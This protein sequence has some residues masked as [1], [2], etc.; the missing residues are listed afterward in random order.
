MRKTL[1][2]ILALI[3]ALSCMG[4]AV[5]EP[6]DAE[7]V[8]EVVAEIEEV[9]I[10]ASNE[11]TDHN[12]TDP[13]KDTGEGDGSELPTAKPT[14]EP[15]PT[16]APTGK[17]GLDGKDNDHSHQPA[18]DAVIVDQKK[19]T[20]TEEGLRKVSKCK[21]CGFAYEVVIPKLSATGEHTFSAA[22]IEKQAS[23]CSVQGY[24]IY[25]KCDKCGETN[26]KVMLP[27]A[28]H[29]WEKKTDDPEAKE[30]T[31]TT[32]EVEVLVCK[33]CQTR[34]V[35]TLKDTKL[36]HDYKDPDDATQPY[37]PKNPKQERTNAADNIVPAKDATCTTEGR[38]KDM[39]ACW[40]CGALKPGQEQDGPAITLPLDHVDCIV[41]LRDGSDSE[42]RYFV[43]VKEAD[44]DKYCVEP[45]T[46][47]M[48]N[49]VGKYTLKQS[50]YKVVD[51]FWVSKA[52]GERLIVGYSSD[53]KADGAEHVVPA[54]KGY[55]REYYTA[56][57]PTCTTEGKITIKC[58][59]CGKVVERTIPA[60]GHKNKIDDNSDDPLYE[61]AKSDDFHYNC[62]EDAKLIW[63]CVVCGDYYESTIPAAYAKHDYDCDTTDPE[64][65]DYWLQTIPGEKQKKIVNTFTKDADGNNVD[66][67]KVATCYEYT[68]VYRCKNKFFADNKAYEA[69]CTYELKV[70]VAGDGKHNY[71]HEWLVKES[72]TC[73]EDGYRYFYCLDCKQAVR[74][75]IPAH[76]HYYEYVDEDVAIDALTLK[77]VGH[78]DKIT[79]APTCTAEGVRTLYCKVCNKAAETE[80]VPALG[81]EFRKNDKE[82]KDETC[83]E[84]GLLVEYCSRCN[85]KRTTVL[86]KH[87]IYLTLADGYTPKDAN[88]YVTYTAPTCTTDGKISFIC[89]RC[90]G[91][92][93]DQKIAKLGHKSPVKGDK[94]TDVKYEGV[95]YEGYVP[96]TCKEAAYYWFGCTRPNCPLKDGTVV[97]WEGGK[98]VETPVKKLHKVT[99]GSADPSAHV[100]YDNLDEKQ[101]QALVIFT[102]PTCES[103]GVAYYTCPICNKPVELKLNKLP[104]NYVV[105][106]NETTHAYESTCS[107]VYDK[108]Q[109]SGE[110][111]DAAGRK[112]SIAFN[113]NA[114]VDKALTA[115]LVAREKYDSTVKMW[116]LPGIGCGDVETITQKPAS[117]NLTKSGAN[118]T[119]SLKDAGNMIELQNPVLYVVW[120]YTLKDGTQF[121]YTHTVET[122][123]KE[124]HSF[125]IGNPTTPD[126]A[127]LDGILCIVCND[128][129]L[130]SD[131]AYAA[132]KQGYGYELFK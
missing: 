129:E 63:K 108:T 122:Y 130:E 14:A 52:T 51:G 2:L 81:H 60:L 3:L 85:E 47:M 44:W 53:V 123:K 31:C 34:Q 56:T 131:I 4:F 9:G 97:T 5:A 82:S 39:I 20:C 46:Q 109:G 72:A 73:T 117:Y 90:H 21:I 75:T 18:D 114:A 107:R 41:R 17:D 103:E 19:A 124:T 125:R 77:Y 83:F 89:N 68:A 25:A 13:D 79:T 116:Y 45:G 121:S 102:A 8:E 93:V 55:C 12:D 48:Q 54:A 28:D 127:T 15:T 7:A 118:V 37:D 67:Q 24:E 23:S 57:L 96:A 106:W 6:V 30:A 78:T 98:K 88:E 62:T 11:T 32:D 49:Y 29:V 22:P 128:V 104:H 43:Y 80:R 92:V 111:V 112:I 99:V 16:P 100:K 113:S 115:Y 65:A 38:T 64:M 87:H 59:D 95:W 1:A 91:A 101:K 50:D 119:I 61:T 70:K 33:M 76:G 58:E 42:S 105:K 66:F 84:D 10:G 36:G 120:Q 132:A 35:T 110:F 86:E 26:V 40:R 69:Q 74:E 27:L 126:G 71:G 94:D